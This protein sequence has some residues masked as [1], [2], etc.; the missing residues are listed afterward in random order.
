MGKSLFLYNRLVNKIPGISRRYKEYRDKVSGPGRLKAWGYLVLLNFRYYC[1]R[2]KSLKTSYFSEPD[3]GK[4]LDLNGSESENC[5]RIPPRELAQGLL[6]YDVISF[7]V[8]DT[9]IFRGFDFPFSV[10]YKVGEALEYPNFSNIRRKTERKSREI[11]YEK[12]GIREV[13]LEEIWALMEKET[14]LDAAQGLKTELEMEKKYCFANPYFLE[15]VKELKKHGKKIIFIS[16]MY[17]D[18]RR[19]GELLRFCGYPV[20]DDGFVSCEYGRSKHSGELYGLVREKMGKNLSYVHM[21]DNEISDGKKAEEAGFDTVSYAN[22]NKTGNRYRSGD[23]SAITG[24]MYRGIVNS[25]LRSGL[26][27]YSKTYEFGYVYGGLFVLG[28]CQ[29]IHDYALKNKPDKL[30]FLSRDGDILKKVYEELYPEEKP[31]CAYVYWSRTAA[32]KLA[33]RY[34]KYD[35]FRRFL[36]HKINQKYALKDVFRS[37]E[38]EDMLE[39]FLEHS[40]KYSEEYC[41]DE[42]AADDIKGYL[43]ENWEEVLG[44]YTPQAKAA[45]EYY[46]E[47]LGNARSAAAIDIGWAGSG[48]LSLDLM[49]NKVWNLNCPV[50][51]LVAGT[52]SAFTD[53]TDS[54]AP[55][56]Q[57]GKL[58]SYL[59]SDAFNRDIWKKHDPGRG[60]NVIVENLLSSEG[61][62]LK[63]FGKEG[64]VFCE[65]TYETD[66][67]E[68]QR[69]I[70]D[71]V[72][73]FVSIFGKDVPISGR[74][75]MAPIMLLYE[76]P[77]W[78]E[79]VIDT[80]KIKINLE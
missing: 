42:K 66:A 33:A 23:M 67:A 31:R 59:F 72:K 19:I 69:G 39:G 28:Y 3:K 18:S 68:V 8:F 76:N 1:L 4:K 25:H 77:K 64:P 47:I 16:D 45:G 30:L 17:L 2:D 14:G 26:K 32:C 78:L 56:L 34:Y 71:F 75:A 44:H 27:K 40:K 74:D 52:N 38:L 55:F 79:D 35:Y 51:G 7:D 20:F 13:T 29:F 65:K 43:S 53:E 11:K 61:P 73:N 60:H 58:I 63:G 80:K 9:L 70:R 22:V 37:M 12:E 10:F 62:S 6:K 54:S 49:V 50:T 21:G 24:S 5:L 48:A 41:L 15:V 36:Y 46:K 57:N